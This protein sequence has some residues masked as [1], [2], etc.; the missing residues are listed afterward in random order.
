MPW[1]QGKTVK[2]GSKSEKANIC[3][4]KHCKNR[5]KLCIKDKHH[6]YFVIDRKNANQVEILNTSDKHLAKVMFTTN[7]YFKVKPGKTLRLLWNQDK[8]IWTCY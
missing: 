7:K 3:L 4:N 8:N 1:V 6:N 5:F 2:G